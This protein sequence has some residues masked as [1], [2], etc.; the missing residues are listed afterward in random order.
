MPKENRLPKEDVIGPHDF[1]RDEYD[2][3]SNEVTPVPEIQLETW[4]KIVDLAADL[5]DVPAAIVTRA[6]GDEIEVCLASNSADN[7]FFRGM[8]DKAKGYYC[9]EVV[10][11]RNQLLVPNALKDPEW[12]HNPDIELNLIAYLGLPLYWPSGEIFGTI[13]VLD[14]KENNFSPKHQNFLEKMQGAILSD[15]ALITKMEELERAKIALKGLNDNLAEK[16]LIL[17]HQTKELLEAKEIAED[18]KE[19][20]ENAKKM[21]ENANE[22]KSKFLTNMSHELRTP[23][24]AILGFSQLMQVSKKYP[25]TEKQRGFVERIYNSGE[26][27]LELINDILDL[28]KIESGRVD[29]S[30]EKVMVSNLF[31]ACKEVMTPIAHQN[32]IS[33]NFR[34]RDKS[35]SLHCDFTRF[36]Q[37]ILNLCSNAIKY[38]QP[39]GSV[40]IWATQYD[41]ETIRISVK[42]S[43]VG[44]VNDKKEKI[45]EAFNRL[46][47]ENSS[48]EGTGIGLTITQYL[49]EQMN[50]KLNFISKVG[51]G[52]IFYVDMPAG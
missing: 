19:I 45:F 41:A 10:N 31:V 4:Q 24:N 40:I 3:V 12:D 20:A 7:P 47:A 51:K 2:N 27:L 44:I 35:L 48:V 50:G 30:M 26:H 13:C 36:K 5:I 21:A 16:S 39:N 42:D 11:T 38:N 32:G 33:L 22:M 15:L 14:T 6:H 8:T 1:S 29:L 28:S 43:G 23:L 49:V 18:A 52:S 25:L 34:V 9:E 17:E 37:V 46:G